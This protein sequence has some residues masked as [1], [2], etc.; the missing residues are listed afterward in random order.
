M[1]G[2]SPEST[3]PIGNEQEFLLSELLEAD[4]EE[5]KTI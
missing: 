3:V 5:G 1:V 4:A 2:K